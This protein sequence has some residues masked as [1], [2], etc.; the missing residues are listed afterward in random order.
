M[1]S[2]ILTLL[3]VCLILFRVPQNLFELY[4]KYR[5]VRN[6]PGWPTHWLWGNLH[7]LQLNHETAEKWIAYI[8]EHRNK[9]SRF[10]LGP[11]YPIVTV[12]HSDPVSKLIGKLPKDRDVYTYLMPW[13]GE[14]LLIS[15]GKKWMRN[16]RLLT[17]A[18]HHEILRG[19]IP[20]VNSCLEILLNKW[21]DSAKDGVPVCVFRDIS[22]LSLDIIMRCAFSCQ[23]NCQLSDQHP[24]INSV[25]K[26][27]PLV[28]QRFLNP[29]YRINFIYTLT[30]SGRKFKQACKI[31]HEYT[32][33]VIRERRKDLENK[34]KQSDDI[35]NKIGK[36][37]YLDFLDILLTAQD[38]DGKGLTDL[39]IRDEADTFMFEG[40]DTTTSGISWTIYCLAQH[41]EHQDKVREEVKSVLMGRDYLEYDDLK[42]LKYTQWCIKEAMRRYPPVFNFMR[43]TTEDTEIEGH[44]IPKGMTVVF[45]VPSIHHHPDTWEN[46]LEYNPLRFHPSN[47]EGRDPYAFIPFSAGYR[48]CIGQNFALNEEKMVIA[49][50]IN[51][52]NITLDE[53]HEVRILPKVVLRTEN[54]IKIKLVPIS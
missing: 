7:Q 10:W 36:K 49:S 42:E 8:I 2:I 45:Q 44:M 11:F 20:V 27:L 38:E 52:F 23:S 18:F 14:G 47:A 13:L 3:V 35:L 26:L 6:I 37:Q 30:A 24:Y 29:L 22:K 43:V 32:E 17:P 33:S 34:S 40:H 21:T 50:L 51:L 9:V 1:F 16:R 48:N 53:T 54:D 4:R 28:S 12:S 25:N 19:Y 39:E 15:D 5:A 41:P 46:P 31:A